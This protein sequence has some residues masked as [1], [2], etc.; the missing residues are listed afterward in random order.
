[1]D[2]DRVYDGL[3]GTGTFSLTVF[4]CAGF[5]LVSCLSL[6][7]CVAVFVDVDGMDAGGIPCGFCKV[8]TSSLR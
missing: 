3:Q 6:T 5:G 2:Q 1:M 8:M 4:V 7:C